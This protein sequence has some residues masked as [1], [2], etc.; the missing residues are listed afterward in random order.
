M[1]LLSW[2]LNGLEDHNLDMRTEAAMFEILLGAPIESAMAEGFKPSTPDIVVLQEV[3]ERTYHAHIVPHLKAAGFSIF[4]EK[5]SERS[6]FEVVAVRQK[7]IESSYTPFEYSDQGR[8]LTLVKLEGLTIMTAHLESMKPGAS[9]RIEQA[10]FV[11]QKMANHS[12]CIFAGDTNLR[13]SEWLALDQSN[14]KDAWVSADSPKAHRTT[15]QQGK[16]KSRYSRVWL[17]DLDVKSFQTIGKKS[18]ALI[19]ERA[20]DHFG[21]RVEFDILNKP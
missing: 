5:P 19:N 16:Y 1:I 7:I 11:L 15:W 12:P 10:Q 14:V 18:V 17:Q 9:M 3:V 13:K 8:G 20:S 6:Y 21:M 4:P 2:N